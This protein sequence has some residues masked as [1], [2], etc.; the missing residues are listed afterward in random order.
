MAFSAFALASLSG[1]YAGAETDL[2]LSRA[3][4]SMVVCYVAGWV[5][6]AAI[7]HVLG[8][9]LREEHRVDQHTVPTARGSS[10][11]PNGGKR[12]AAAA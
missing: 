10:S 1:L 2:V 8:E 11:A 4:I 12:N 5:I 6:G 7:E 3:L 9:R